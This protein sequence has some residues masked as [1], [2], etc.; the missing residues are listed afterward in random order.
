MYSVV[1]ERKKLYLHVPAKFI[2]YILSLSN[3]FCLLTK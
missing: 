3:V 1:N 2:A